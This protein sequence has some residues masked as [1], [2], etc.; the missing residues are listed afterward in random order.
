MS[1]SQKHKDEQPALSLAEYQKLSAGRNEVIIMAY[2][3]GVYSRSRY[4]PS[5]PALPI[6]FLFKNQSGFPNINGFG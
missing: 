2:A 5:K 6:E 1:I 3:T 4:F